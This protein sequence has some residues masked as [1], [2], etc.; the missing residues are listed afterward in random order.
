MY[1]F[2]VLCILI[3]VL[4]TI[5]ESAKNKRNKVKSSST[6]STPNAGKGTG[7]QDPAIPSVNISKLEFCEGCKV[8]VEAYSLAS[9]R[10]MRDMQAR[11]VLP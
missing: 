2:T 5:A 3:T 10:R 7:Q 4:L 1:S 6:S 11:K 9:Y 8:T